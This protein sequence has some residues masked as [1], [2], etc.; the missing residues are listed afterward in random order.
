MKH[1]IAVVALMLLFT[2]SADGQNLGIG[3]RA[4]TTGVGADVA[5][6]LTRKLNVRGHFSTFSYGY[7]ESTTS[8]DPNLSVDAEAGIGAIAGMIDFHP[9]GNSFRL[10]VGAGQNNF[11]VTGT[12]TSLD[13]VCMGDEDG[14]G[15][16]LGKEFSPDKLGSLRANVSYPSAIQPYMGIGFGNL[17]R[18]RS[19]ITFLL[20][21]G[22]FYTGAPEIDL[23][24]DGLFRPTTD[25]D[26]VQVLNDGLESFVWYPVLTLGVGIRI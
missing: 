10:T 18:G 23:Q 26:N 7:T 11:D 4:G 1:V 8:Q 15:N 20:D 3:L 6:N 12:G 22:A 14:A 17:A 9:F 2:G 21:I 5:F 24:N 13:S 16:C 25:P 19:V